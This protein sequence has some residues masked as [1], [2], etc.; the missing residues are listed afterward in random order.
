M[1][2]EGAQV[3]GDNAAKNRGAKQATGAFTWLCF[4]LCKVAL[5]K[6]TA[7]LH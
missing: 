2:S 5:V 3:V 6:I 1:S 4:V 7:A